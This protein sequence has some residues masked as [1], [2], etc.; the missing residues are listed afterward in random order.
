LENDPVT[1]WDLLGQITVGYKGTT[2]K[3]TFSISFGAVQP[4]S[5]RARGK[6]P[7]SNDPG[8]KM[9]IA[10]R[11]NKREILC[12]KKVQLSQIART[13]YDYS[14]Y[15]PNTRKDWHFDTGLFIGDAWPPVADVIDEP[16]G[17]NSAWRIKQEFETVAVCTEGDDKYTAYGAVTWGHEISWKD[18]NRKSPTNWVR[19]WA[20]LG[21]SAADTNWVLYNTL[22]SIQLSGPGMMPTQ[23]WIGMFQSEVDLWYS[24]EGPFPPGM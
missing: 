6:P 8:S 24:D 23:R 15:W 10:W 18:R 1:N 12:C 3:G 7:I 17:P 9:S 14:W 2:I 19:R 20:A 13:E 5:P 11:P 16:G 21:N 22:P 4:P